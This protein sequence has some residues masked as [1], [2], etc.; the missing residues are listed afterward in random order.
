VQ[1]KA[2]HAC[3]MSLLGRESGLSKASSTVASKHFC[4]Y[5][6]DGWEHQTAAVIAAI[7][8]LA[9]GSS[10]NSNARHIHHVFNSWGWESR[11]QH[12]ANRGS[13]AVGLK[14]TGWTV[15]PNKK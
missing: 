15:M 14:R 11:S 8:R 12:V 1:G 5:T 3:G 10:N 13:H 4:M 9:V 6:Q 2:A 7:G